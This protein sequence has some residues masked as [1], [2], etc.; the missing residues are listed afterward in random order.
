MSD[1][2]VG[3]A[4]PLVLICLLRCGLTGALSQAALSLELHEV[5]AQRARE[6][7]ALSEDIYLPR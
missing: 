1:A 7:R 5:W 2:H 3:N 4:A 6:L